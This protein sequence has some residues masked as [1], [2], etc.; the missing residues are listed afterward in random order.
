MR[1][2]VVDRC[3]HQR[4]LPEPDPS[5]WKEQLKEMAREMRRTMGRD[6]GI[7]PRDY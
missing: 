7:A 5:R 6:P 3:L 4:K 2:G 1:A